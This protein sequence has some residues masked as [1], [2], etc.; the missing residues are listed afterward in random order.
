MEDRHRN[1]DEPLVENFDTLPDGAFC[2]PRPA[3]S[4]RRTVLERTEEVLAARARRRFVIRL[5]LLAAAYL[6][7]IVTAFLAT[8]TPTGGTDRE[9]A[10]VDG[11]TADSPADPDE[12]VR[13]ADSAPAGERTRLLTEA[14]DL[15]LTDHYDVEQALRCY[16]RA[17]NAMPPS[18]RSAAEPEDTWL[19]A[20]L[21]DS[22]K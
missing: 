19:L 12:L 4:L 13:R 17:L 20:A 8:G 21:K 18:A 15:Y 7:G 9:I 10:I 11:S 2:L 14:G 6:G 3:D 22:R 5:A 1:E 16:R